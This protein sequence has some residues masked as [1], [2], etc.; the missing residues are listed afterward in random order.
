MG[1]RSAEVGGAGGEVP[2]SIGDASDL[3]RRGGRPAPPPG[4][5]AASVAGVDDD[6]A[7]SDDDD[8]AAAAG[9]AAAG[10]GGGRGGGRGGL[11]IS[12]S[13]LSEKGM[14]QHG[15][16]FWLLAAPTL[17]TS[18]AFIHVRR[19][20]LQKRCAHDVTTTAPCEPTVS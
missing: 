11:W 8:A 10:G 9:A 12:M 13:W 14:R 3:P 17:I 19:H 15:Q 18:E 7:A 20:D 4:V 6:A 1:H 16:S 2:A 5:G